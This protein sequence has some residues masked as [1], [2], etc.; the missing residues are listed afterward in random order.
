MVVGLVEDHRHVDVEARDRI[1]ERDAAR[2]RLLEQQ[3]ALEELVQPGLRA[4]FL[5]ERVQRSRRLATVSLPS[6]VTRQSGA[7]GVEHRGDAHEAFD[8]VLGIAAQLDLEKAQAVARDRS[9]EC[10]RQ[11]VVRIDTG[12]GCD[13]PVG[14]TDG[15]TDVD[16]RRRV[17]LELQR[18]RIAEHAGAQARYPVEP[19]RAQ[20]SIGHGLVELGGAELRREPRQAKLDAARDRCGAGVLRQLM[21]RHRRGFALVCIAREA[22]R[23]AQ[24]LE[25]LLMREIG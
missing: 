18:E 4:Q 1:V 22:Q 21:R 3:R 19:G 13:E 5:P 6:S 16:G 17:Q 15:V 10:G 25:V 14:E 23:H 7:A 9:L 20:R 8:V 12:V 2:Q 11:T 24:L